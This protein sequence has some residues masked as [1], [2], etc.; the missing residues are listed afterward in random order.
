MALAISQSE[1]SAL[2]VEERI[3]LAQ[4]IWGSIAAAPKP[5]PLSES[6]Q[7]ELDRR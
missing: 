5:L 3:E 4:A 7:R 2:S 1:I 6:Q